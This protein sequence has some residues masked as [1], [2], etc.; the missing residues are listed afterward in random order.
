[1]SLM[2]A[3]LMRLEHDTVKKKKKVT[4]LGKLHAEKGE[5]VQ[6]CTLVALLH[7]SDVGV[8]FTTAMPPA[9][10]PSKSENKA[11]FPHALNIYR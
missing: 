1:M 7:S 4:E 3:T 9:K 6:C 8:S 10:S 2:R 5:R 11:C